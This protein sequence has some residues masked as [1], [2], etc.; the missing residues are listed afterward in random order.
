MSAR[1]FNGREVLAGR[2]GLRQPQIAIDVLVL[3]ENGAAQVYQRYEGS[4]P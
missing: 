1:S 4:K 3:S 2:P